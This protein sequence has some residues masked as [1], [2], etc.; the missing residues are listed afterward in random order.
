MAGLEADISSYR[1]PLPVSPLDTAAKVG[2]LEQ[3]KQSIDAGKMQNANTAL[4]HMTRAMTSLGPD[5]TKEE[6]A[7]VAENAVRQGLVPKEQLNVYMERLNKAPSPKAF[8]NEFAT[9]A[10][11]LQEQLNYHL[12]VP[13]QSATGQTVTPTVT[14]VKPGFGV[15]PTG[16][17]VQMQAPPTTP[18]VGPSG[19]PQLLG[20][21]PPQLAPGTAAVPTPLPA[22]RPSAPS[23]AAPIVPRSLPVQRVSGPTGETIR[24]TDLEPTTFENRFPVPTG[25]ATGTAPL[26]EEGKKTYAQDQLN[27]STRAQ[28]VKP[29]IQAL[30]LMPG[31]ITGPGTEQFNT[32]VAALKAWG[33]IDTKENDPTVIRQEINKKLAQYVSGSPVAQRSDAAQTLAEAGSPNPKVQLTQALQSLTRD[34]IALDRV[35]ILKPQAFKGQK[36]DDYIKHTGNFPQ[37]IDEKALTLDLMDDKEREKLVTKMKTEYKNGDATA[38]KRAVKF[39]ETLQLARDAKLY[40]GD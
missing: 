37:S 40:E 2:A 18:V 19:Q 30:K 7:A 10:A 24:R 9:A 13:G 28:S 6:Y 8:F 33:I 16:L 27:A 32:G 22:E 20:A 15:R 11:T 31:I 14:S 36:F 17:P 34:A 21:Q 29:A 1:Q 25:A 26:F 5:A 4:Q 38:K 35:Q 3:Q 23:S 39:F 12:G